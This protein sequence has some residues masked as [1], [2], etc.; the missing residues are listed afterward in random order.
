MGAIPYCGPAPQPDGILAAWNLDPVVLIALAMLGWTLRRHGAAAK[1]GLALLVIAY[2]SPL[3]ALSAG[4]FSART[5]H[6]LV[7]VFGAAPLLAGALQ[8]RRVPLVPAFMFHLAVFWLWHLPAAYDFALTSD[9]AYW[10]GQIALLGSALLLWRSLGQAGQSPTTVFFVIAAMVMQM[11]MLGAV[12]TFAPTALYSSHY[13]TT[14]RYGI[15][16]LDDQQFAGLLMWVGSLPL[17]IVAAWAPLARL[18]T[19]A[20]SGLAA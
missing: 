4:L 13:L 16:V 10:V 9:V 8:T 14:V 18:A 20:R 3:C 6:H 2:V 12:L 11:G 5:V 17:T 7:I 15:G 19:Q 1:V